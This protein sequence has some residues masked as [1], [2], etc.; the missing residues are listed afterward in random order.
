MEEDADIPVPVVNEG[1]PTL[2]AY[3]LL[4]LVKESTFTEIGT[5]RTSLH[6]SAGSRLVAGTVNRRF[7][8]F[9][10]H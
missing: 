5:Q 3:T 2:L 8:A 4:F 10:D 1:R 9:A 6:L 7:S